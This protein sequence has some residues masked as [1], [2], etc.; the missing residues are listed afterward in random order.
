MCPTS[1]HLRHCVE[2]DPHPLL[3]GVSLLV[4]PHD[5]GAVVFLPDV[6]KGEAGFESAIWGW[7]VSPASSLLIFLYFMYQFWVIYGLNELRLDWCTL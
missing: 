2:D 3:G 5:D 1:S 7:L 6:A 4:Y